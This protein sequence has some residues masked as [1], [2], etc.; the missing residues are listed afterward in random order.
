[1]SQMRN[2]VVVAAGM[3]GLSAVGQ[4]LQHLPAHYDAAILVA[5][6]LEG[7]PPS[8][9][10]EVLQS[11][12]A[13][14]VAYAQTGMQIEP[15]RVILAPPSQCLRVTA[16][17]TLTT[18][19]ATFSDVLVSSADQLFASAAATHGPKVVGVVLSGRSHSGTRGLE[20]IEAAGGVG[21]VQ[22]PDTASSPEMPDAV[23]RDDHPDHCLAVKDI[24]AL[25]LRLSAPTV[26]A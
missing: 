10:L 18:E 1:M 22:R 16:Q 24:A 5:L 21:I 20:A 15:K 13:F 3:G 2:V 4:L 11:Y 14:P 25:L 9:V 23:L 12:S 6:R 8:S 19:P 17:G 7:Q 26:A